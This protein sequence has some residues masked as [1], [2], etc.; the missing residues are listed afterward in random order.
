MPESGCAHPPNFCAANLEVLPRP[1]G[2]S[3]PQAYRLHTCAP[4]SGPRRD[5]RGLGEHRKVGQ[6]GRS[7]RDAQPQVSDFWKRFE[8]PGESLHFNETLERTV[9]GEGGK[10]HPQRRSGGRGKRVSA[11]RRLQGLNTASLG[12][13]PSPPQLLRPPKK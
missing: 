1:G 5:P 3:D 10:N 2:G 13:F 9:E 7:A 12:T 6:G 8:K 4:V 11:Q